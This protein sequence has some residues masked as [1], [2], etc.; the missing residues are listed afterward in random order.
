MNVINKIKDSGNIAYNKSVV[1]NINIDK[2]YMEEEKKE[3]G[4][5]SVAQQHL[6]FRKKFITR[7]QKSKKVPKS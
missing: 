4:A 7:I 1:Y 2:Q 3:K 5:K 6:S